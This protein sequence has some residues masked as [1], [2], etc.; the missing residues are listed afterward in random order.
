VVREL[1][2]GFARLDH[3]HQLDLYC[4]T[5]APELRLDERFRWREISLPD[6]AWHVGAAAAANRTCD[7]FF[8]TNSYLTLWFTRVPA[9]L[10]VYDLVSFVPGASPQRRAQLIERATIR[11]ALKSARRVVCISN[12]TE[13]DLVKRFPGVRS[14]TLVVHLAANSRFVRNG[15]NGDLDRVRHRYAL[16]KPFV[17]ATGTLE[18]RKNLPRLIEA[19]AGLPAAVRDSVQLVLVGEEGWQTEETLERAR[20]HAEA[21]KLLGYVPDDDLA[22]L[23][24][25]CSVFCFPSLYEGFGLPLLEAL[26][27]G[28]P[29]I[30]SNVASLPEVGGDGV[31]YVDPRDVGELRGALHELLGSESERRMLSERGLQQA[32]KFSRERTAR[33]VL[34]VLVGA[35]A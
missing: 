18:P 7:V 31:R 23:Y 14:K 9:V 16:E 22:A 34:D 5:P 10:L 2:T 13:H 11:R 4:R 8:S 3:D 26:Q 33:A 6:P 29:S 35:A 20:A 28:A 24:Q 15:R 17:L 1:L 19:F 21:V 25:L 12:A 32:A 27:T 30:S